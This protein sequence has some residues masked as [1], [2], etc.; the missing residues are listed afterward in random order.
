MVACIN[1]FFLMLRGIPWYG[2]TAVHAL[3]EG[4]LD[5]FQ[6]GVIV[7][8]AALN[9]GVY[10]VLWGNCLKKASP[11]PF[12]N[13]Q[14]GLKVLRLLSCCGVFGKTLCCVCEESF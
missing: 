6:F 10:R 8:K 2:Y 5:C 3:I 11:T 13:F 1:S 9:S 7:N 14:T 4:Y 12:K